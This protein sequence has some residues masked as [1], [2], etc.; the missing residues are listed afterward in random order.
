MTAFAKHRIAPNAMMFVV[1][2]LGLVGLDRLNTQFLPDFDLNI[3]RVSTPWEGASA[4]DVQE[5]LAIPIEQA[6]LGLTEVDRV[7]TT[8]IEGRASMTV[9]LKESSPPIDQM[10]TEI[11]KAIALLNLPEGAG[12][13][14]VEEFVIFDPV[15]DVLL[16]GDL[17]LDELQQLTDDAE[18]S[19][20]SAGITKVDITGLPT[21]QLEA[22][23]P[24]ENYL[25]LD[26]GLT[27]LGQQIAGRNINAPAGITGEN[28]IASQLRIR[29]EVQT[30]ERLGRQIVTLDDQV[31]SLNQIA[32]VTMTRDDSEARLYYQGQPA[33][34]LSLSRTSGEDTLEMADTLAIWQDEFERSLPQGARIHIYNE[35]YEF[36]Q[37][38]VNIILENGLGGMV[39]VLIVLFLFLNHRLAWWVAVGVPVSFLATFVFLEL[40]GNSINVISLLGFLIALGVIVD[41]AIVVGENAYANMEHGDDP[42]RAAIK[43]AR[44]MLPAVVASSITTIAAFL[45]L[46][47]VGGNAGA[48]TKGVPIVVIMAIAASLIECFIILPGHLAHS[49]KKG[50]AQ[51]PSRFRR[52]FE[53]GFDF[54]RQ[55]VVRRLVTKAVN[56]RATTFAF[57][58]VALVLAF[59]LVSTGR[60][61]FVFFP[62]IQS[63]E[64]QLRAEFSEGT[65]PEVVTGFLSD[66]EAA[67]FAV[68]S[69]SGEA[70]IDTVVLETN[71]GSPE[72]GG[73]FVQL[74]ADTER[75]LTNA[76]IIQR[77][78]S[79]VAAP[80]GLKNLNF[81]EGQQGPSSNGVSIRLINEDLAQLKAATD[82][83][84]S[85]LADITGLIEIEDDIP[86][87]AEQLDL[88]LTPDAEALGLTPN[89]LAR[90][91]RETVDG[92]TVQSLQVSG[93]E[94]DVLLR[95]EAA[96][97]D[98]WFALSQFP[99]TLPTG[100]A[101]PL[102]ALAEP[103]SDRAIQQLSR[104][105]GELSAVVTA[106]LADRR[107][108]LT[109]VNQ[110]I[111]TDVR[112]AL[113]DQYPNIQLDVEGDQAAQAEFFEDVRIGGMLG[114]LLI[115]IALA[116]VF[117]SWSWPFAVI[118][119]IPFALTG[120]I[121][122][123]WILGLELSVLSIYGLFGLS[124]III[125]DSIVLVSFYRQLREQ[126]MGI[127]EA[128]IEASVQRFRAVLLTTLT[129]VGGLTPLL[130]E[131]S[132]DA[133]FLIPLGAGI[134]FGLMYGI[135]LILLFVPAMLVSI[136]RF[137]LLIGRRRTSSP[138]AV[139]S[140]A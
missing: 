60:V 9:T 3:V 95:I 97:T 40:T 120:A 107:V 98:V 75:K 17:S 37:S 119:A 29:N 93:D 34:R 27:T 12:D 134:A 18:R 83:V 86:L 82:F 28:A 84:K 26:R 49:F 102:S 74:N 108:N 7:S 54:I 99:I 68:E 129:T 112:Q 66:M 94:L 20:K 130:M 24:V 72:E 35:A 30:E 45:P 109:E 64:V 88:T 77:W 23:L 57:V 47:L 135:V 73:L 118:S 117:E 41:D 111:D 116:W 136:E 101:R 52:Q 80:A 126:G 53:R 71:T 50:Q 36:V 110:T 5:G 22:T 105:D 132:F 139:A 91:L 87:G 48:F 106:K 39:L 125:N 56:Y 123:H 11:E 138:A 124:G 127:E 55:R 65:S 137:N 4:E 2:F 8:S 79:S 25:S 67:L 10:I 61:K 128:V 115:F 38:R 51:A 32:D 92:Y 90:A 133:Q 96:H 62:A 113:L 15:A 89:D 59:M 42:E 14:L 103:S 1:I 69:E 58:V 122:G 81:V 21:R 85:E 16:Y 44:R 140:E 76:E 13:V 100:E 46:L 114:L 6:I 121:V 70:F 104:I 43:A 63:P 78:R 31:L 33:V 19:L 131:T